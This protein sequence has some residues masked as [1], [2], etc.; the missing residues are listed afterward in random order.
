MTET[1]SRL[2]FRVRSREV[3]PSLEL[4]GT[5][6]TGFTLSINNSHEKYNISYHTAIK[7]IFQIISNINKILLH[8][9][10]ISESIW[11]CFYQFLTTNQS[12]EELTIDCCLTLDQTKELS[13]SLS[14][15]RTLETL[16][17]LNVWERDDELNGCKKIFEMLHIN[18]ALTVV[19]LTCQ[20][21]RLRLSCVAECLLQNKSLRV[22]RLSKCKIHQNTDI[23]LC[24][25]FLR[26]TSIHTLSVELISTN[27]DTSLERL[28]HAL[29]KNETIE[30]FELK[31]LG[32]SAIFHRKQQSPENEN[33][34]VSSSSARISIHPSRSKC[35][36]FLDWLCC[37]DDDHCHD[38]HEEIIH[39]LVVLTQENNSKHISI[40]PFYTLCNH[41]SLY[42]QMQEIAQNFKLEELQ[43]TIGDH[44]K[45]TDITLSMKSNLTVTELRI[46]KRMLTIK[47]IDMLVEALR[48]NITITHLNL[49]EINISIN[50]IRQIFDVLRE[51]GTLRILEV[52]HCI[53]HSD[54]DE[55]TQEIKAL[56]LIN[57]SLKV[58]YENQ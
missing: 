41:P 10:I 15:N 23:K 43:V 36:R 37:L 27:C 29:N 19:T 3:T 54:R 2:I 35:K 50:Y 33:N 20:T 6:E 1:N 22:L 55:F 58:V 51:D 32:C 11:T 5:K 13:L 48:N 16:Y 25:N 12:L 56:E 42:K 31:G 40:E 53:S 46:S 49:N 9:G 34:V 57:P 44:V 45:M 8:N 24:E 4:V 26:N 52:K 28:A 18:A 14:G 47:D 39:P 38:P 7:N 30:T 17:L 21:D